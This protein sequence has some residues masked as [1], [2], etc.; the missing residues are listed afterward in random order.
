[1]TQVQSI[2]IW[3]AAEQSKAFEA[4]ARFHGAANPTTPAGRDSV[5]AFLRTVADALAGPAQPR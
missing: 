3:Q 4:L 1:M 5:A 2:Q